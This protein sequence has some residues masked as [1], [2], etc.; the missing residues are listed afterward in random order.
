MH[1]PTLRPHPPLRQRVV[2]GSVS[3]RGGR[4]GEARPRPTVCTPRS[5]SVALRWCRGPALMVLAALVAASCGSDVRG[6]PVADRRVI[7]AEG[8]G[9]ATP[10]AVQAPTPTPA[11]VIGDAPPL[12]AADSTTAMPLTGLARTDRAGLPAI[13]VRIDNTRDALPQRGLAE[14]DVVIENL[15]E[16]APEPT[17]G[18]LSTPTLPESV[19]PVRSAR[20]T[21]VDLPRGVRSPGASGTGRPTMASSNPS[22]LGVAEQPTGSSSTSASTRFPVP[23]RPRRG[24]GAGG[25]TE[26]LRLRRTT[27][28][29]SPSCGPRPR[30]PRRCSSIDPTERQPALDPS[31]WCLAFVS[32]GAHSRT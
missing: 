10:G 18:G 6:L 26:R 28:P 1:P 19:G 31:R 12:D 32:I 23:L 30:R 16:G 27:R 29:R 3:S 13:A 4:R 22:S 5:R 21:D 17:P 2:R 15:V 24:G 7:A 20:S 11:P 14:A 25:R 8:V 9:I